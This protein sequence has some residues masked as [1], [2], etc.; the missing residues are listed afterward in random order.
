M[1]QSRSATVI[2]GTF[3]LA[4]AVIGLGVAFVPATGDWLGFSLPLALV[5]AGIVS[6]LASRTT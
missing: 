2:V 6:L 5:V 1:R 3:C 4:L